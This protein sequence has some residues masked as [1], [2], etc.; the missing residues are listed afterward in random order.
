MDLVEQIYRVTK[1]F[2]KEEIYGLSS[3][4]RRAAVSIPSNIAEGHCR[5]GRREFVH[6][7]SIA[8]GSLGELETQVTIAKRLGYFG[9]HESTDLLALAEET[10]RILVGLMHSLERHAAAS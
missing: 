10:G 1:S 8:L 4:L 5:N 6:H 7:L 2:P 9:A 3:Q